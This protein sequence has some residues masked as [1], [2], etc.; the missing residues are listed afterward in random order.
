MRMSVLFILKDFVDSNVIDSIL[1]TCDDVKLEHPDRLFLFSLRNA[2][3]IPSKQHILE[4]V[5][6]VPLELF[7][8]AVRAYVID[9]YIGRKYQ[10][11]GQIASL[12]NLPRKTCEAINYLINDWILNDIIS[13]KMAIDDVANFFW[14]TYGLEKRKSEIIVALVKENLERLQFVF[15]AQQIKNMRQQVDSIIKNQAKI[16]AGIQSIVGNQRFIVNNQKTETLY[17]KEV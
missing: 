6:S 2:P 17:T 10:N 14:H 5:D 8:K 13:G 1:S 4:I 9:F 7:E 12:F 16:L 15:Q 11:N 3:R